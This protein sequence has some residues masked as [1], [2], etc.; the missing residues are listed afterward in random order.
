M[1]PA[2]EPTEPAHTVID[3]GGEPWPRILGLLER[4][5]GQLPDAGVVE[6][7]SAN[8]DVRVGVHAWC[9][10]GTGELLDETVTGEQACYRIR[11]WPPPSSAAPSSLPNPEAS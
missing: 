3:A 6:V 9:G 11:L 1:P 8:P 10:S 5:L 2:T 7:H 4:C